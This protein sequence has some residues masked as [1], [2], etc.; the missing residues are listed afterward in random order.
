[1]KDR[2]KKL[3]SDP[4]KARQQALE[5]ICSKWRLLILETLLHKPMRYSAIREALHHLGISEKILIQEL[6]TLVELGI[7][8]RKSYQSMPPHVEYGFTDKGNVILPLLDQLQQTGQRLL[9]AP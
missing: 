6:K 2:L 8:Y 3:L 7:L 1:M 9:T 4:Q 5:I